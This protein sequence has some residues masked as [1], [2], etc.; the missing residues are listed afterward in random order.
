MKDSSLCC[1]ESYAGSER[2]GERRLS[3]A[4]KTF[5]DGDELARHIDCDD[6]YALSFAG[7][8]AV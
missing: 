2:S 8:G 7:S 3:R 4:T 1:C 5:E 6:A